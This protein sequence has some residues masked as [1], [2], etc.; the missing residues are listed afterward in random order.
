M[1]EFPAEPEPTPVVAE[2]VP[3]VLESPVVPEPPAVAE[4]T[5][6]VTPATVLP[7]A[8][9]PATVM[10][11]TI[12]PAAITPSAPIAGAPTDEP[13][14]GPPVAR[15]EWGRVDADG[16]VYVRTAEG[17]R[18][19]GSW[20][21]GTPAEA[22]EFY[23]RRFDGLAVEVDLLEHRV[24]DSDVP[25]KEAKT[26]IER[27]RASLADVAAIG[28]LSGLETRI[29]KLEELAK[30][31][32]GQARAARAKIVAETR[33][34][35][36]R[37]VADA[38]AVGSG[39]DWRVGA[40]RLRVLLEEWKAA[41]RLD[42]RSDDELWG[43]FSAAR[44]SFAKRRK[45]HYAE[46]TTSRDSAK[47][48]KEALVAKAEALSTFTDWGST[49]DAYRNLMRDWK[50]S[51]RASREVDDAL[52]ERFKGAQDQFFAA[53]NAS[54]AAK[55]AELATNLAAKEALVVEAERLVPV[56]NAASARSALRGIQD[57]WEKA[58]SL[59]RDGRGKIEARLAAVESAVREAE[60]AARHR[61][62][63]AARARA[64]E[65]VDS[66]LAS[67]AK[68]EK[69]AEKARTA[70]NAKS[71]KDAEESVDAR[72]E[73]LMEA[74]KLLTEFS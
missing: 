38:E 57:R 63:P 11:A 58:G 35:K 46:L 70:G 41:P 31:R 47:A 4:P 1:N 42:R 72:R 44:S 51:P 27:L 22:L 50:A 71:L 74:E 67:I 53:R 55:D 52:W 17:E 54:F 65:A 25:E 30:R 19:I 60:E 37:I 73:W 62:N 59:P 6:R 21:A 28:D 33:I 26:A 20:Q 29:T 7:D 45:V 64:Q 5:A 15:E 2:A 8:I 23:G 56:S 39:S 48:Q 36:E 43:R 40:E 9:T 18:A 49:S 68:F 69:Q 34:V 14:A 13:A 66:I 24:R 3:V 10:S 61:S 16:I 32:A 12:S